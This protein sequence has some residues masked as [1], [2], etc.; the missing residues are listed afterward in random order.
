MCFKRLQKVSSIWQLFGEKYLQFDNHLACAGVWY[1]DDPDCSSSVSLN[2]L[3]AYQHRH[4]IANW[5]NKLGGALTHKLNMDCSL[6][7]LDW[8]LCFLDHIKFSFSSLAFFFRS[9]WGVGIQNMHFKRLVTCIT[10]AGT[11][12]SILLELLFPLQAARLWCLGNSWS[13]LPC[14]ETFGVL[15][16]KVW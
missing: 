5:L 16:L 6:L 10:M 12:V 4:M 8:H 11:Q 1:R 14:W 15:Y 9:F 7:Q 2:I 13:S 3:K